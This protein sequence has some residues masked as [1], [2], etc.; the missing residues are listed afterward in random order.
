MNTGSILNKRC[1]GGAELISFRDPM[2]I[3]A[4]MRKSQMS[5]EIIAIHRYDYSSLRG[6]MNWSCGRLD[7]YGVLEDQI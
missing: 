4:D 2:P 3:A 6:V 7:A 5:L 1:L